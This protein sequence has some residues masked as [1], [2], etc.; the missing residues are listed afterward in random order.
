MKINISTLVNFGIWL[1]SLV[2]LS[3]ATLINFKRFFP[4]NWTGKH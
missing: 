2:I 1:S 3:D 4:I